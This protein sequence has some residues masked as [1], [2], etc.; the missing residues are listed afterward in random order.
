ML[1]YW[2]ALGLTAIRFEEFR[3]S[4]WSIGVIAICIAVVDEALNLVLSCHFGEILKRE[5]CKVSRLIE[6]RMFWLF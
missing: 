1:I 2:F 3:K 5:V 6:Q 4:G